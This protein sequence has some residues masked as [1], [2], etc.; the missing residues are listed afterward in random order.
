MADMKG[1]VVYVGP[2]V[3]IGPRGRRKT[4]TI[5]HTYM[6]LSFDKDS[7]YNKRERGDFCGPIYPKAI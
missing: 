7:A 2:D 5:E 6:M 1:R 4:N 3:L